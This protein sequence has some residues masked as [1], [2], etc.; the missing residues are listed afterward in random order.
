MSWMAAAVIGSSL[1]GGMASSNAASQQAATAQQSMAMQQAQQAQNQANNHPF[2][3]AG[4]TA[5]NQIGQMTA[6]GGSMSTPF[7][8]QDL[9]NNLSPSYAFG[10]QQGLGQ[11]QNQANASGGMVSGNALQG[12]NTFAQNYAQNGAQQAY[13]NYTTNQNNIFN[14]LSSIASLGQNAAAGVGNTGMNAANNA[15][16]YLTQAGNAQASGTMGAANG[17]GNALT[18]GAYYLNNSQPSSAPASNGVMGG[19]SA[20]SIMFSGANN[21][22]YSDPRLKANIVNIGS[23][24]YGLGLYSWNYIWDETRRFIGV[25]ADEVKEIMPE[26]VIA[27]EYMSVNYGMLGITMKEIA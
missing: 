3:N 21:N 10:L 11:A 24:V 26:A 16:N 8:A 6:P 22:P 18:S 23:T 27:G 7:T 4:T 25:M 1:I 19:N 13:N 14:R 9:A 12:L 5:I 2:M 15:G 17:M 20:N